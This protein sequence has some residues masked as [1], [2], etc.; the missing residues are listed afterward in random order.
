MH[1]KYIPAVPSVRSTQWAALIQVF[2]LIFLLFFKLKDPYCRP[3]YSFP[4]RSAIFLA[5]FNEGHAYL[6]ILF[7]SFNCSI[8]TTLRLHVRPKIFA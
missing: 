1:I 2:S 5:Q 3:V 8:A 6:S 7:S 4:V